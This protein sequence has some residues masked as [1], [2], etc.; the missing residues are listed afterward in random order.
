ML[1]LLPTLFILIV[2]ISCTNTVK[3]NSTKVLPLTVKPKRVCEIPL[4]PNYQRLQQDSN[5]FGYFLQ[6]IKLKADNTV[7]YYDGAKK[8]NQDLHYAV[9]DIPLPQKD[10]QQC[11]DAIMRLRAMYFFER[12][13]YTKIEFKSA[14][15]VL[16]FDTFLRNT[17]IEN[18]NAAFNIYLEKVFNNCGT[19]NLSDMLH[20][21]Q[22]LNNIEAGDVF[23]KGGS[24]GHAMIVVDVAINKA[25][26]QR[27][28]LLAQSFMPA[29][30]VH[31]VVNENNENL[32]PWYIANANTAIVTPGY[33]FSTHHL[34]S[35]Q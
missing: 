21:K 26:N 25:T 35:W 18:V 4:P 7:Y 23:V 22:S 28:Y 14:A 19:Y 17:D 1:K 13:E 12:K 5:S 2:S 3:E 32:S 11:A 27:I 10:L 16:N 8:L 31:I 9:L 33:I 15:M 24:P 29:Q 30:S 20:S 34:K 6:H